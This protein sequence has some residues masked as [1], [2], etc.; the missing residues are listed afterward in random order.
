MADPKTDP[1]VQPP[2]FGSGAPAEP[3]AAQPPGGFKAWSPLD[4][5][6]TEPPQVQPPANTSPPRPIGGFGVLPPP[7]EPW[8]PTNT[9]GFA[10]QGATAPVQPP[11][12]VTT[13]KIEGVNQNGPIVAVHGLVEGVAAAARFDKAD[14]LAIPNIEERKRYVA[15]HLKS[16]AEQDQ[17]RN[18][19]QLSPDLDLRGEIR[20]ETPIPAVIPVGPVVIKEHEDGAKTDRADDDGKALDQSP[21]GSPSS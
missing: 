18:P 5:P 14:L 19:I 10:P 17:A 12:Q 15:S 3:P 2:T 8:S 16:V 11:M 4:G 7:Q 21:V 20:I 1:A 9:L 6:A 13:I